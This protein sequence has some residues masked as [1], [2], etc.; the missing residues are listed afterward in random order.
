MGRGAAIGEKRKMKIY[1]T[2]KFDQTIKEALN[3][4]QCNFK[5]LNAPERFEY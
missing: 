2:S 4:N 5:P 3:D 1:R